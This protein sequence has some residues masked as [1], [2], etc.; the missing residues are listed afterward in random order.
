MFEYSGIPNYATPAGVQTIK[1]TFPDRSM[2]RAVS[3][4]DVPIIYNNNNVSIMAW[5]GAFIG[6]MST[7]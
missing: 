4:S 7:L 6:S 3:A 1:M 5:F 2:T